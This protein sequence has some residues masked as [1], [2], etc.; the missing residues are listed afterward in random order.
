MTSWR[1][2][3]LIL[4]GSLVTQ[5]TARGQGAPAGPQLELTLAK[6][7]A[8]ARKKAPAARL[9]KARVDEARGRVAGASVLLRH[10]P[11][12]EVGG[13]PR[14]GP[15]GVG[16]DL[17]VGLGLT[18]EP[19]R[20]GARVAAATAGVERASA[21]AGDA[22][23]AVLL[24]VARAFLRARHARERQLIA[25]QAAK[26]AAEVH[27]VARTRHQAGESGLLDENLAA[28]S[29]A[30]AKAEAQTAA[31]GEVRALGVLAVLLGLKPGTR[32]AL[33]GP[34]LERRKHRRELLLA[35]VGGRS[36]LRA[37][38]A[39]KKQAGAQ[40]RLA[41]AEAWPELGLK[42]GYGRE[43]QAHL[44]LASLS[45]SLPLFNRAQGGRAVAAARSKRLGLQRAVAENA[46]RG[47]IVT[48]HQTYRQLLKA[49]TQFE[50]QGL[51]RLA[52][53]RDL[54]QK[55][56]RAGDMPLT[57]LLAVRQELVGARRAYADLQ[58]GAALARVELEAEAGVLR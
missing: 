25:E 22:T 1:I 18:L 26:L 44:A 14:F 42:L 45:L 51:T 2:V 50:G 56:Y 35:G 21:A 13:G 4:V 15:D 31:A 54:A 48:A 34:L 29:L 32:L 5:G 28:L 6:A 9:A 20:R 27:R 53:T 55:K 57:G 33:K 10:N 12:L 40:A 8:L 36:D 52:R 17:D 46:A 47:K 11:E 16:V 49:V 37:L 58:L 3:G 19:G 30:R 24:R 41:R 7:L 43:E 23:R 38:D 39:A